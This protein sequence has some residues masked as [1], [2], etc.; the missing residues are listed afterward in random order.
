VT[1]LDQFDTTGRAR[2][3]TLTKPKRLCNPV[4]KTVKSGTTP[5]A[6]PSL[7]L[8][9][10]PVKQRVPDPTFTVFVD[11]QFPTRS[12]GGERKLLTGGKPVQLCLPSYKSL[13]QTP[14]PT[15]SEPLANLD[16]F[17]CYAAKDVTDAPAGGVP[18]KVK[19]SDE[20]TPP[21]GVVASIGELVMLCNP[22]TK[23]V[24]GRVFAPR[25]PTFHLVCWAIQNPTE[26]PNRVFTSNQF[27]PTSTPR[28]LVV[29]T[30]PNEHRTLCVPSFKRIA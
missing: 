27:N 24:G 18:A 13:T 8:V 3:V 23:S 7:H 21:G 16:H 26:A 10:F 17:K 5:A 12:R 19:L 22:V 25:H 30:L 14:P 6:H 1:L 4:T 9:C 15:G 28:A 29:G 20:F 2:T 11:N